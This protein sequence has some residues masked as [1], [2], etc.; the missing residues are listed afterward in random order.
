[1]KNNL[2][3]KIRSQTGASITFA[4]LLFLVCAVLCSVILTA[5]T[6]SSGRM[7]GMA[8]ADQRYYAVTSA[9]ELL[10]NLI[11]GQSV[12]IE[13]IYSGTKTETQ[14]GTS[15]DYDDP[16]LKNPTLK[17]NSVEIK[18]DPEFN[19]FVEAA[20]YKYYKKSDETGSYTLKSSS[21]LNSALGI[22]DPNL[23]SVQISE[24]VDASGDITMTVE[25][26]YKLQLL[27][28]ASVINSGS[29][30]TPGPG[31]SIIKNVSATEYAIETPMTKTVTT[32]ITWTL[33]EIK[34]NPGG[35]S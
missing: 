5:A 28:S 10:K 13:K 7:S 14:D 2:I 3:K 32:T 20:A 11:D 35:E 19:S 16:T 26:G 27:F 15:T 23:L 30:E 22:S 12:T 25:K 34:T 24:K 29:V 31:E 1:M 33:S 18:G 9:A 17:I 8:E 4:L 21:G 6:V